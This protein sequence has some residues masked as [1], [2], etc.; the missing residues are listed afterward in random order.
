MTAKQIE[1]IFNDAGVKG[2][3]VSNQ[4]QLNKVMRVYPT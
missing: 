2:A 4:F 3:I 1:F